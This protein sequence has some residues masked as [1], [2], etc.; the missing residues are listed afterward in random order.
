AF[1]FRAELATAFGTPAAG[2]LRLVASLEATDGA[3]LMQQLGL[4]AVELFSGGGETLA[5][6]FLEGSADDGLSGRVGLS[7]GTE[8]VGFAGKLGCTDTGAL[9]GRGRVEARLLGGDG[10]AALAGLEGAGLGGLDL[11][12]GIDFDGSGA[13]TLDDIAGL[14]GPLAFDGRLALD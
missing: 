5:S 14:A 9:R 4:G 7:S 11:V 1:D 12:A 2:D 8:N 3:H 6:L 10:V 13:V